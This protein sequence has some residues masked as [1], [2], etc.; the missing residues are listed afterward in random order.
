[1]T[2]NETIQKE[3]SS[4]S[5][6]D[7]EVLDDAPWPDRNIGNEMMMEPID[8]VQHFYSQ[9][10]SADDELAYAKTINND[11]DLIEIKTDEEHHCEVTLY[12]NVAVY[13]FYQFRSHYE[14]HSS[15]ALVR[16]LDRFNVKLPVEFITSHQNMTIYLTGINDKIVVRTADGEEEYPLDLRMGKIRLVEAMTWMISGDALNAL[17]DWASEQGLQNRPDLIVEQLVQNELDKAIHEQELALAEIEMAE[18][19]VAAASVAT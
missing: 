16:L 2:E 15:R 19:R 8:R 3:Q 18:K 11:V 1:M 14:G 4:A 17:Y 10:R 5:K 9:Y 7:M 6:V 12:S 13:H